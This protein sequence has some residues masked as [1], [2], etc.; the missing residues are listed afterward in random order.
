M[1]TKK[2]YWNSLK[3]WCELFFKKLWEIFKL[4]K[5]VKTV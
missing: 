3:K 5:L 1:G 2:T 4:V